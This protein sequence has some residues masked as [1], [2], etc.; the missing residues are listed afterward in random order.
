[1]MD[2]AGKRVLIVGL[3]R[4]GRA[5]A[6]CFARRGAIVTVTDTRQPWTFGEEIR[7]LMALKMGL[8][9]GQHREETFL[10]QDLIVISPGVFPEPP[11]LRA[12]RQQGIPIVPE[13]EAASWFLESCL[14]GITG[15][16]GKTTTTALLGKI[17]EASGYQTFVG[18]NIGQALISAVDRVFRD[19]V[20]V[21]ELSSFQLEHIRDFRARVAV[22]LNLTPN[23]LDRHVSF[24]AYL[25]A[26]AQIFRNQTAEDLAVLNA[27]DPTVM[28]LAAEIPSRKIFFSRKQNLPAGVFVADGTIRYRVGDLERVVLET[29][30]VP[31]RGEFNVENVL[32]GV[33]TACVLGADFAAQRRA[34]RE[35]PGVEHRLEYVREIRGVEF[36]NDSKATSV[37]ATVKALSAF[38]RG[39]HLILGGKDKG[40]PYAPIQRLLEGRVRYV[41]V[42]GAAAERIAKELVGAVEL[43]RVGDLRHAVREAFRLA[44]PGD[45]ILLSPA[46]ASFDQFQDFEQRGRV[47]KE[48]VEE[49]AREVE[50]TGSENQHVEELRLAPPDITSRGPQAE[51]EPEQIPKGDPQGAPVHAAPPE[52]RSRTAEVPQPAGSPS[53]EPEGAEGNRLAPEEAAAEPGG[54]R[55]PDDRQPVASPGVTS[56]RVATPRE[57]IYVYEVAAEEIAYPEADAESLGDHFQP[58]SPDDLRPLEPTEDEALP[59]EIRTEGSG[60]ESS[61]SAQDSLEGTNQGESPKGGKGQTRLPGM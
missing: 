47:F 11:A 41:Y 34:V 56:P 22:L 19:A 44:V 48:L 35:F 51:P 10:H 28:S 13:V 15:S 52:A 9:L 27:D 54:A 31:L 4:S 26:K 30:E 50:L 5:A 29:R 60:G 18:G 16:N 36:F 61:V 17:L 46:C 40:A 2:V 7:E 25:R 42:I 59:F 1:M 43:L 21:A 12:A 58:L 6:R 39:V 55:L 53:A 20:V 57:L 32:A 45:V 24:E 8:E 49:V 23:H 14:V 33:A 38:E 3:A 37:D